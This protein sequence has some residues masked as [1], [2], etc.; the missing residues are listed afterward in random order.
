[1][2]HQE[3]VSSSYIADVI[4]RAGSQIAAYHTAMECVR[5]HARVVLHFHPDRFGTKPFPVAE[6]L[7]KEGV[8]RNQFETGLSTGSLSAFPGGARDSWERSLFGGAYHAGGV[9][10]SERPKYGALELVRYADGPIP[11]FGSCYFVMQPT[12]SSRTSFTFAG[13]ED[14]RATER[15]GTIGQMDNVMAA[16]FAEIEAGGMAAPPWPPFRAPTLGLSNLTVASLLDVLRELASPKEEPADLPAGR[17]LDT[18]I[19]AQ[20]H[21]PVDLQEDI[22]LLVADPAFARTTTGETLRELALRY[23]FPLRWHCG[24]QL[25]VGRVPEDFRGPAMPRLAQRIADENGMIDAAVI[26]TA[27]A[28]LHHHPELWRDWGSREEALQH[29]KQLWHVLVHYGAPAHRTTDDF[30]SD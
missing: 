24:F 25:A 26:G 28:S 6:A 23:G 14:P 15:L 29:L 16:L 12:V 21:G 4:H 17:V 1:M 7:L 20:V 18:Q 9:S 27:E 8:Y 11:R 19:E 22:E 5:V 10:D 13:S 30:L 2:H 3:A